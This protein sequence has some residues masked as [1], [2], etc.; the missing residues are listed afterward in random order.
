MD[1]GERH[2]RKTNCMRLKLIRLTQNSTQTLGMLFV[3][4]KTKKVFECCTLEAKPI[5][6]GKYETEKFNSPKN[7]A[8]VL[9]KNVPNRSMI[10]IHV[11]NY[12][13]DSTG[14]IL[15]GSAFSDINQDGFIDV[16]NSRATLKKLLDV[17]DEE[18]VIAI[19]E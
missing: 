18:S 11:G 16:T 19:F 12:F 9:L 3:F 1:A 6:A 13:N 2:V 5:P 4:D 10:E 15:V 8:C 17:L 7:G 14:C